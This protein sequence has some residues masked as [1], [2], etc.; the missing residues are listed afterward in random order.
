MSNSNFHKYVWR[1]ITFVSIWALLSLFRLVIP[2]IVLGEK[3]AVQTTK[4]HLCVHTRL[5][6]EV[7]ERKIQQSFTLIREMGAGQIVEFFPWAYVETAPNQDDWTH[8]D[9]IMRHAENQG[10]KIIARM[11]LV[12]AWA[13]PDP[14]STFNTIPPAAYHAFAQFVGRFALRY[15]HVVSHVI[16]W[17]EPNLTFEWGFQH[18]DSKAYTDLLRTVYPIVKQKAP[19]V[20][21][22]GGALAPTIEPEGSP[23]GLNDLI[24]LEQMIEYGALNYL[25]GL[26]I[27]TYGFLSPPSAIPAFDTLNFRR[28]ELIQALLTT[29][30][31][32]DFPLYIT[33]MGW[34]DHPRWVN[35]VRPSQRI[36][37]TIGAL[38]QVESWYNVYSACLWVFRLPTPTFGYMDY[39]TLTTTD[40]ELKPLYY[41]LQSYANGQEMDANTLWLPR[42]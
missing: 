38:Q 28:V 35:A 15:A 31:M 18:V 11:G 5:T 32:P 16:I 19:S 7:D 34:N 37:Y 3:Q 23:H 24:Y 26:A 40:F 14:L 25:D 2:P 10:I 29:H 20:G 27:H 42:P 8:Y 39:F 12:P 4:P 33:E 1:G 22:L 13:R 30:A 41:A 9:K 21:I 17:N 6:E 36:A